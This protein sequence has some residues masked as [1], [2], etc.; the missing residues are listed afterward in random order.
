MSKRARLKLQNK[1]MEIGSDKLSRGQNVKCLN[2]PIDDLFAN[3][4]VLTYKYCYQNE[5][6]RI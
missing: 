4:K 3:L 2:S 5:N 1:E 6:E